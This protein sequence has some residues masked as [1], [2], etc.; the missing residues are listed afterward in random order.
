M[1]SSILGRWRRWAAAPPSLL[2]SSPGSAPPVAAVVVVVA[3]VGIGVGVDSILRRWQTYFVS[4][5]QTIMC[6]VLGLSFSGFV[7]WGLPFML[8]SVE[9][10]QICKQQQTN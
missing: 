6:V 2:L 1:L 8:V 10:G 7:E 5:Q 9:F 3:A 4:Q